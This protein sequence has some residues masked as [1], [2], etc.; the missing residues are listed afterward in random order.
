MHT[1]RWFGLFDRARERRR[2]L[3]AP[4]ASHLAKVFTNFREVQ[5]LNT[6][7]WRR[8][9]PSGN[10]IELVWHYGVFR[11][12]I[13]DTWEPPIEE[14]EELDFRIPF[15]F[16]G[17]IHDGIV[18]QAVDTNAPRAHKVDVR[19]TPLTVQRAIGYGL[20]DHTDAEAAG[21]WLDPRK[22]LVDG[23][24]VWLERFR[25]P[26][27]DDFN[28][29]FHPAIVTT[30][31][32][33]QFDK[34]RPSWYSGG[35]A[36]VA[37]IIGGWGRQ[38]M[39]ALPEKSAWERLDWP[40]PPDAREWLTA[41]IKQQGE[42]V[43]PAYAGMVDGTIRYDMGIA[44][45]DLVS[46]GLD[47][48][49]WLVNI[50]RDGVYAMPLPIVPLTALAAFRRFMVEVGDTE[51]LSILDRFRGIPSGERMPS[52]EARE[53]WVRAG[54]ILKLGDTADFYEATAQYYPY[55][56]WSCDSQGRTAYD[57]G[58]R[59]AEGGI[60]ESL[61][62]KLA[63]TIPHLPIDMPFGW[64][65]PQDTSELSSDQLARMTAYLAELNT[66]LRLADPA[67][68]NPIFYKLARASAEELVDAAREE[69]TVT[70][71]G[72]KTFDPIVAGASAKCSCVATGKIY[73]PGK[74]NSVANSGFKVP[75]WDGLQWGV[76]DIPTIA[77]DYTGKPPRCDTVI[78][79]FFNH[80]ELQVVKYFF[81]PEE[82]KPT[83]NA[84]PRDGLIG[85]WT[86]TTTGGGGTLMG[87]FYTTAY[88]PR[89]EVEPS[90]TEHVQSVQHLAFSNPI[91]WK[92][93]P[94]SAIGYAERTEWLQTC[95]EESS[96]QGVSAWSAFVAPW[97]HRN[98][99]YFASGRGSQSS[100]K[101]KVYDV[102]YVP[103][104]SHYEFWTYAMGAYNVGQT[105]SGNQGSPRPIGGRPVYIDTRYDAGLYWVVYPQSDYP[106]PYYWTNPEWGKESNSQ[107]WLEMGGAYKDVTDL[108]FKTYYLRG[109]YAFPERVF[110]NTGIEPK[111]SLPPNGG[112]IKGPQST[113]VSRVQ[114]ATAGDYVIRQEVH[115]DFIR[116]SPDPDSG[117]PWQV[118][119]NASM[120]GCD[121]EQ[122][123]DPWGGTVRMGDAPCAN[124]TGWPHFI[125]AL[126]NE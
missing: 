81:D 16:C 71:W 24:H 116:W 102:C 1:P 65:K 92:D 60:T 119:A 73:A 70:A 15:L 43:L 109:N 75:Y 27:H 53:A 97:G 124:P 8:K 30:Q 14:V 6:L 28:M 123:T 105:S 55:Q 69:R 46:F 122:C 99:I 62:Y 40:I 41:E 34:L 78:F 72:A 38:D 82:S 96:E 42:P 125:G 85:E 107:D 47:G 37:Q 12:F 36:Q 52:G 18:A 39:D 100:A 77:P 20:I 11:V 112:S 49:P 26:Y 59:L 64:A 84:Q 79:G 90:T 23:D 91:F 13:D 54:A 7:H 114:F 121:F 35:M 17:A 5:G 98:T 61:G 88:D 87:R 118:Q 25:V 29:M 68:A 95:S 106:G 33:T 93:A 103:D 22:E 120:M 44:H 21:T 4:A 50:S 83:T 67:V 115:P 86:T 56:G 113:G 80:D 58:W 101:S 117:V 10:P 66:D 57:T 51:V 63:I 32:Y 45:T 19:V 48:A 31:L 104:N 89:V 9:L 2:H 74:I 111:W 110:M 3:D 94:P 126:T 76:Q 108:A